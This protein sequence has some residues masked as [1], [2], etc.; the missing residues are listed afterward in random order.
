MDE[1]QIE[2]MF[3]KLTEAVTQLTASNVKQESQIGSQTALINSLKNKGKKVPE[4]EPFDL[5]GGTTL[6][7]FFV[8]FGSYCTDL[9]GD[10]KDTKKD[11]WSPVLKKFLEGEVKEAYIGLKGGNLKWALLKNTLTKQFADTVQ[12]TKNFKIHFNALKREE[13][14]SL[15]AFSIRVSRICECAHPYYGSDELA[16]TTKSKFLEKLPY[17]VAEKMAIIMVDT[18]LSAYEYSKL[19]TL[20]ERF[21]MLCPKIVIVETADKVE[22]KASEPTTGDVQAAVSL[23]PNGGALPKNHN[24]NLITKAEINVTGIGGNAKVHD[25]LAN[26]LLLGADFIRKNKFII[27]MSNNNVVK[28]SN[29]IEVKTNFQVNATNN[30]IKSKTILINK[31]DLNQTINPNKQ[32]S[33]IRLAETFNLKPHHSTIVQY[34]VII[35]DNL[36]IQSSVVNS[37]TN[38]ILM[39]IINCS[40]EVVQLKK[41]TIVAYAQ[42]LVKRCNGEL[43][44]TGFEWVKKEVNTNQYK[45]SE[46]FMEM[47]RMNEAN[48]T[49]EE[50]KRIEILLNKYAKCISLNDNDVGKTSNIKHNIELI[51][52]I[53][54]KQ[55]IRRVNGELAERIEKTLGQDHK[56]GI[57]RP[58]NS[59]WSSCI[60]PI[61][62]KC[63]G[64]RLAVD[65]R[66]LNSLTVKDSF[67]L[68]NL[69]DALYNYF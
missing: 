10:T 14:E 43:A 40:D 3:K 13:S 46:S 32:N 4:P 53:A 6:P 60:V 23:R 35:N 66:I 50:N 12:R 39:P 62:K 49:K 51:K 33:E 37:N 65:Y 45:K 7:D 57:I 41:G 20:A 63:G 5:D 30:I 38:Q 21:E 68:P 24:V 9:Y 15:L 34:N 16:D 2:S 64:L 17:E 8:H 18:E 31:N 58:S 67:P 59:P 54:I 52:D 48:L 69:N 44:E 28:N 25:E 36:M 22:I 11:A 27:D 1:Q 56:D 19:V 42:K 61:V 47:F 26:E 55:P 29:N